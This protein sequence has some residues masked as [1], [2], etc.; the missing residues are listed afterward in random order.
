[1]DPRYLSNNLLEYGV[2][3][4]RLAG[5]ILAWEM[6]PSDSRPS[7]PMVL[8]WMD[9]MMAK[10]WT[11]KISGIK[12]P[13]GHSLARIFAHLLMFLDVG[14]EIAYIKGEKNIVADFLSRIYQT[15][16]FSSFTY[17][18]LQIQ[19]PWLK[20]SRHFIPS[21]ELL[22][23]ISMALLRPSVAIPTM[24]IK[25]GHLQAEPPTLK[26]NFFRLP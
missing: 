18:K 7:H 5:A 24:R 22:V 23:L 17:Q 10:A 9:N 16:N 19:F 2:I 14:I 21:S 11:K 12:T 4:F 25:L 3:I 15:Y 6:L 26:Q 20:L 1:M 13:Q 8:L